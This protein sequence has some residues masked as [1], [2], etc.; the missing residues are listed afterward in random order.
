[1]FGRK[2][3]LGISFG[4]KKKKMGFYNDFGVGML[5]QFVLNYRTPHEALFEVINTGNIFFLTLTI[6]GRRF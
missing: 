1:M 3:V 6:S 5:P 2:H 4:G